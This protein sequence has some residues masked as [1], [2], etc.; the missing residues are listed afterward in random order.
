MNAPDIPVGAR[1][2][3]TA[4]TGIVRWTGVN[5]KFSAGRWVGIEL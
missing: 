2:S 4:G 5:P 3:V 1:V